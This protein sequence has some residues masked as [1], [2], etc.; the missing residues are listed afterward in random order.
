MDK[1][2][3]EITTSEKGS[4]SVSASPYKFSKELRDECIE[5]FEQENGKILTHGQ[6]DLILRN[7]AGVG[8]ALLK[9][10]S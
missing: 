5:C 7:F 2:T 8:M 10:V 4:Q 3:L 6:A 1:Q 9:E